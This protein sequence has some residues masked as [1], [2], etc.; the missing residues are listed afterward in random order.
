MVLEREPKNVKALFRRGLARKGLGS[1]E[2]AVRGASRHGDMTLTRHRLRSDAGRR[3][4]ESI[5][6]G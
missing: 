3:C 4:Y 1:Y 2:S 6:E 5:G